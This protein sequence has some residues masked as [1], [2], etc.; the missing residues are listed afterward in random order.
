MSKRLGLDR[1]SE[2]FGFWERLS[3]QAGAKAAA[4]AAMKAA[5][6]KA[7]M[8]AGKSL[9][10]RAASSWAKATWPLGRLWALGV[11]IG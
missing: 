9:V 8:T 11:D 6:K 5:A 2:I 10:T 7:A 3:A 1:A 4:K